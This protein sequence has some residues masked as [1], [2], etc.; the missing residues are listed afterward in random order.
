[1]NRPDVWPVFC[2][3][4]LAKTSLWRT[5]LR[6]P[7]A[8]PARRIEPGQPLYEFGPH[9]LVQCDGVLREQG[10]VW[11]WVERATGLD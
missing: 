3:G 7:A 4:H 6:H 2:R 8:F 5:V 1:M 11:H 10:V 9:A